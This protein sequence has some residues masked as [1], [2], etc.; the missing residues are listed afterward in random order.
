[1][2]IA[3]ADRM[4]VGHY[5]VGFLRNAFEC[6]ADGRFLAV[7]IGKLKRSKSTAY[8]ECPPTVLRDSEI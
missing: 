5:V 6:L 8:D 7:A 1:V 4:P 3:S 2:K